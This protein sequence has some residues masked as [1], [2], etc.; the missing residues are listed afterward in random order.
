MAPGVSGGS[1][2]EYLSERVARCLGYH[3]FRGAK[4]PIAPVLLDKIPRVEYEFPRI[5]DLGSS[6]IE[7]TRSYSLRLKV[8]NNEGNLLGRI[9][10]SRRLGMVTVIAI[11]HLEAH[12]AFSPLLLYVASRQVELF[13]RQVDD[14]AYFG[15]ILRVRLHR[16][17]RGHVLV[18]Q[19]RGRTR[20][21]ILED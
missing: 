12:L 2:T 3:A 14:V 7:V 17:D 13:G 10:S 8:G 5:S 9:P 6:R 4:Q 20:R 21:T 18:G 1:V 15:D 19:S 16:V 11:H